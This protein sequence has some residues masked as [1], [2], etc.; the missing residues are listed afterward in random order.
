MKCPRIVL[1]FLLSVF[2]LGIVNTGATALTEEDIKKVQLE[3]WT[4]M[5]VTEV[6]DL[7]P[8]AIQYAIVNEDPLPMFKAN[9]AFLRS[10]PKLNDDILINLQVAWDAIFKKVTGE[11]VGLLP[12]NSENEFSM[13]SN[14]PGGQKWVITKVALKSNGTILC[15]CIPVEVKIGERYQ[16]K[17]DEKNTFDLQKFI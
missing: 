12:P 14:E 5:F 3:T 2:L 11:K 4:I 10:N 6:N 7:Y 17:L 1:L 8:S 9:L 13:G 16:I 15:W